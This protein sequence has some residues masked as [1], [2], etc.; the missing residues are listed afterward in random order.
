MTHVVHTEVVQ[1]LGDLNL[2]LS[3]EE[4]IG[5]LFA[6]TQS[7]LDNLEVGD[8]AQEVANWLVWVVS[9]RAGGDKTTEALTT[10]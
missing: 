6:L 1:R 5:E 9:R 4:G 3:I 8:I 2:L 10:V 7:T